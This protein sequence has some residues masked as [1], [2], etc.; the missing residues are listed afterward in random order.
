MHMD[1]R[2]QRTYEVPPHA[3]NTRG[4]PRRVGLEVE[5]GGLSLERTLDV[6]QATLGGRVEVRSRTEGRVQDTAYGSFSAEFDHAILRERSY[7]HPFEKLGLIAREDSALA[8]RFE[9]S[10]LKVA[11][12][13]VPIEV[14]TPPIAW[15]LLDRLDPLWS[16]L[17][18]AGAEDTHDSLLYA[19]GLHLNPE[20]P[21]LDGGTLLAF[22]RAF[23][24]LED[25]LEEISHIDISRRISPF[26][27]SFPEAYRRKVLVFDYAPDALAFADDYLADNPTR[28][29]PLDL[30][31][32]LVHVHGQRLLE[33]MDE[34][35]LVKPRPTFHYRMPN[36]E[37]AKPGWTPALDWNRWLAVERLASDARMLEILSAAYLETLDLPLRLQRGGWAVHVRQQMVLPE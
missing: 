18:H 6:I 20:V 25:W 33:R 13:I 28:N 4:E 30:H 16:A 19:F 5:I 31:P 22:V 34:A 15:H 8:Q 21:A 23:L 3:Y 26:I 36:C 17:R 1:G 27:R 35:S 9:D 10:V 11:A 32:L 29:R 2:Y 14:V 12:E 7:L 37:L 24:L